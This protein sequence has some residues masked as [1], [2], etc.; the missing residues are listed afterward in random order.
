MRTSLCL[1]RSVPS[2][3]CL[4]VNYLLT[5][6]YDTGQRRTNRIT[7]DVS[8]TLF[9]LQSTWRETGRQSKCGH[10]FLLMYLCGREVNTCLFFTARRLHLVCA[11]TDAL[12]KQRKPP[13]HTY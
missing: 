7:K 10:S 4:R 12:I 8:A 5:W 3:G 2:R 11:N 13:S 6:L 9:R 1:F